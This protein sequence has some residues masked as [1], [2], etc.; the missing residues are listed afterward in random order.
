MERLELIRV[1]GIEMLLRGVQQY[2]DANVVECS[3]CDN[4]HLTFFTQFKQHLELLQRLAPASVGVGVTIDQRD[5]WPWYL[6]R[7]E[8]AE[9]GLLQ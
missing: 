2:L 3:C 5:T 6:P 1:A 9:Q 8:R 4:K 7:A